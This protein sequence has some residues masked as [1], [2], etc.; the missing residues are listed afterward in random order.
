MERFFS[1]TQLHCN[2]V[3]FVPGNHELHHLQYTKV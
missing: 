3:I 1:L 2:L